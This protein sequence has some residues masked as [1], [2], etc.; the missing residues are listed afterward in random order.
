MI[1]YEKNF[2]EGNPRYHLHDHFNVW[3][4]K[5]QRFVHYYEMEIGEECEFPKPKQYVSNNND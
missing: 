5:E 2:I 4:R 3:D 1:D